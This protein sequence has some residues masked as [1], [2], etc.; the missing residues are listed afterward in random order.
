[1]ATAAAR[2][3]RRHESGSRGLG[4]QIAKLTRAKAH[5]CD[6]SDAEFED[7]AQPVADKQLHC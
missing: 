7:E 4:E 2:N 1:M 6:G 3:S 5:W